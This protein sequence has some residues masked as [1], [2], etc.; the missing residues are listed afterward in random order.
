MLKISSSVTESIIPPDSSRA[1]SANSQ[2]AGFPIRIAVATVSGLAIGSPWT[3][4]AEPSASKP[5]ILGKPDC[6][7][8]LYSLKPFQ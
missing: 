4:A 7:T 1:A 6:F 3:I 8:S 2:L 5:N